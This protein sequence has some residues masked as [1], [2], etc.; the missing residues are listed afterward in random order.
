M[1]QNLSRRIYPCTARDRGIEL[2]AEWERPG[3][4]DE[5]R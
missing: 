5:H 4:R 3:L 1:Q 2:N